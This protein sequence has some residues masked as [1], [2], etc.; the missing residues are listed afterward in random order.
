MEE[1][2][3]TR[4]TTIASRRAFTLI[5]VLV[6]IGITALLLGILLPVL[7][8]A[9]DTARISHSGSNLRQLGAATHT[10]LTNYNNHLPQ[11]AWDVGG[12]NMA[13]I[14]ALFGGKKGELPFFGIDQVGADRRPLNRYLGPRADENE[15]VPVF[16][17]PLDI[18][19]PD[20]G[21]GATD[22]LYDYLGS[23]YTMND[24]ALEGEG[25]ST[26]IPTVGPDG[27]PGGRM[28][29]IEDTTRTWV[30]AEHPIYNYQQDGDRRQRWYDGEVRAS[31]W[32]LD[33]HTALAVE[34]PPGITNTT[35]DYTFL[36]SRDWVFP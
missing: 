28:P 3:M 30:I 35:K 27:R 16:E 10:Y 36:P 17:S 8:S 5:E 32:F 4:T 22:S 18:G 23:S 11:Y 7:A 13:I 29:P 26:L 33:G 20:T 1:L 25:F 34:I 2:T 31:M 15:E 14:A 21:F 9:S 12:G 24:H 6:V 19:Q